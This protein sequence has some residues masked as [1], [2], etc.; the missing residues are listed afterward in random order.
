MYNPS[1]GFTLQYPSIN[2]ELNRTLLVS[3]VNHHAFPKMATVV[4]F[5]YES[6][7]CSKSAWDAF[8]VKTFAHR[9]AHT[10]AHAHS[11]LP[12]HS[13]SSCMS[14]EHSWQI[15]CLF[16]PFLYFPNGT[17]STIICVWW[18]PPSPLDSN[19]C[20]DGSLILLSLYTPLD[21]SVSEQSLAHLTR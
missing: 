10:H 9:C 12:P 18:R 14:Q 7:W 8:S 1:L 6:K 17:H 21:S 5:P 20:K 4:W 16:S 15:L 11:S 2:V 19:Q 13:A 3:S